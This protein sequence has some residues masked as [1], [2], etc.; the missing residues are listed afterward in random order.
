[1]VSAMS[2]QTAWMRSKD[3]PLLFVTDVLGATPEPWQ[4]AALEAVG[5]VQLGDA[6]LEG[7]DAQ[8]RPR[9]V[10][11]DRD[12]AAGAAGGVAHALRRLGVLGGGAVREVQP[13]DVH[14]GVDHPHE[15]LRI[16]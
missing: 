13:R 11:Q 9:E 5:N 6:L 7:A 16:A 2:W 12:L 3:N 4:A 8:L 15:R 14:P 10:L 1:M